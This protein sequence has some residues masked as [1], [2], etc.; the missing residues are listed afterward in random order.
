MSFWSQNPAVPGWIDT[1]QGWW[2][3]TLSKPRILDSPGTLKSVPQISGIQIRQVETLQDLYAV[4]TL[5]W[6]FFS[7]SP[8]VRC[9]VPVSVLEERWKSGSWDIWIAVRLDTSEIVGTVVRRHYKNLKIG[10]AKF[11][12]A[13]GVDYFCVHPAWRRKNLGRALLSILHN[14]QRPL[15]LH[16]IFWESFQMSIPPLTSGWFWSRS[17]G[18]LRN[19]DWRQLEGQERQ[20]LWTRIPKPLWWCETPEWKETS[21]WYRSSTNEWVIVWNQF[22]RTVPEGKHIA[23]IVGYSSAESANSFADWAE[24][25]WSVFLL[26]SS[27]PIAP[28]SSDPQ[29]TLDSPYCWI[30][31]NLGGGQGRWGEQ[32]FLCS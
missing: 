19:L 31:Y 25:G 28:P 12:R 29:W 11:P 3:D 2:Q 4:R 13:S 9:D 20:A 32:P 1:L 21:L 26:S 6:R 30:A 16:L 15:E 24:N 14:T 5:W 18:S 17:R 22:H 23:L 27:T 10:L 7:P 8:K